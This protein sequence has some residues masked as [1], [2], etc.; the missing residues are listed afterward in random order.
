MAS[1]ATL[2]TKVDPKDKALFSKTA[3]ALG[4]NAST[5]LKVFVLKF[6]ECGGFPFDVRRAPKINYD[7]PSV[8]HSSIQNG[9]LV[10]PTAWRD[11]D[12]D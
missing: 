10:V 2:N 7:N 5:A 1:N 12:D 8:L 6:N 11:D 9:K 4:M 3:E